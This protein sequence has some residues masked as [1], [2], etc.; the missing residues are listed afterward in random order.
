MF[1]R[2]TDRARKIMGLANQI[3]QHFNKDMI[4]TGHVLLGLIKEGT[5][6]AA[7]ILKDLDVDLEKLR[8]DAEKAIE[9]GPD[10]VVMGKLPQTPQT[11]KVIEFAIKEAEKMNHNYVG[12]EHILLGL[13][14]ESE[15]A[16]ARDLIIKHGV[17]YEKALK[18]IPRLLGEETETTE[19]E[20]P[21]LKV[22]GE[23][24]DKIIDSI[25]EFKKLLDAAISKY[26]QD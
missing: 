3:A 24:L 18:E 7:H 15:G 17:T 22:L 8:L 25:K 23:K 12:S 16:I 14:Q 10:M 5:G 19:T 6:V 11:K 9:P 20:K 1:Q 26:S 13:L 2:F 21:S 4:N